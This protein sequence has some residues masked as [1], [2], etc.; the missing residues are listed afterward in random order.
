MGTPNSPVLVCGF[1]EVR[2]AIVVWTVDGRRVAVHRSGLVELGLITC[3]VRGIGQAAK[4]LG[5]RADERLTRAFGL[6]KARRRRC[7]RERREC[8][9]EVTVQE[10]QG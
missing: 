2:D 10:Q 1:R 7:G 5:A 9:L 6:G 8:G 4:L 3:G